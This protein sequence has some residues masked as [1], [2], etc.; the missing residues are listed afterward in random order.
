MHSVDLAYSVAAEA[1]WRE[2]GHK[3]LLNSSSFRRRSLPESTGDLM[4]LRNDL[5]PH[6]VHTGRSPRIFS[7]RVHVETL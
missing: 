6:T 3:S 4:N 2:Q 1:D 5:G 7:W